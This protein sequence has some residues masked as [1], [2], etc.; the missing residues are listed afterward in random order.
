MKNTCKIQQPSMPIIMYSATHPILNKT[1]TNQRQNN[2]NFLNFF[3]KVPFMT[4]I[5]HYTPVRTALALTDFLK[6]TLLFN[7]QNQQWGVT[8]SQPNQWECDR[9]RNVSSRSLRLVTTD[10]KS[11]NIPTPHFPNTSF[12]HQT[13]KSQPVRALIKNKKTTVFYLLIFF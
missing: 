3:K 11:I 8:D 5:H 6:Q 1:K 9:K 12:S 10:R 13:H 2:V 4:N 7:G